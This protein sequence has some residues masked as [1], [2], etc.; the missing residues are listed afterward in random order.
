MHS[1]CHRSWLKRRHPAAAETLENDLLKGLADVVSGVPTQELWG[2][3]Q[4]KRRRDPNYQTHL[5]FFLEIWG[6]RRSQ[7]LSLTAPTFQDDP[8]PV[9]ALIDHYV[10]DL[11][12]R[13]AAGN[14]NNDDDGGPAARTAHHARAREG[15]TAA[16]LDD[17]PVMLRPAL[18]GLL[19]F[20]RN[21]IALRERARLK[22]A[23]LYTRLGPVVRELGRRL[24]ARGVIDHADDVFMLSVDELLDQLS[25]SAMFG[26]FVKETCALRKH[27]HARLVQMQPE[28]SFTIPQGE[29]LPTTG[30]TA[31]PSTESL[32]AADD[33]RVLVGGAAAAGTATAP[34][35]VLKSVAE[36]ARMKRGDVLVTKQTDP[37]WGPVLFLASALV[38]ERGG[39]LSHG[40]I[41]AREFGVPC[42]VGVKDASTRITH[43]STIMVDGGKGTVTADRRNR[44]G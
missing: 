22:Q 37:G 27:Q 40:A 30:P 3:A 34:A 1:G 29:Y 35:A 20:T 2:L 23:L 9:L 25:R 24:H 42:V 19:A 4:R 44:G 13:A 32:S 12:A 31:T 41:I 18:R 21:G 5:A 7:E 16:L 33:G 43:G 8:T 11:D 6:F 36:G 15:A 10:A 28:E 39:M 17:T 26:A 38:I 14:N